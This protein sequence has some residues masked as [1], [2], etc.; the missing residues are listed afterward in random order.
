MNNREEQ[1]TNPS[2]F[3]YNLGLQ[4]SK[5][6]E[7]LSSEYILSKEG[8]TLKRDNETTTPQK[9]ANEIQH[10]L[11]NNGSL[12]L[13]DDHHNI[14]KILTNNDDQS[15]NDEEEEE[16]DFDNTLKYKKLQTLMFSNR[17][18]KFRKPAEE[19]KAAKKLD[20]FLT[21]WFIRYYKVRYLDLEEELKNCRNLE[22]IFEELNKL[23]Y[24]INYTSIR[25]KIMS[26]FEKR[27]LFQ[28]DENIKEPISIWSQNST[29]EILD[30]GKQLGFEKTES[31]LFIMNLYSLFHHFY[32]LLSTE[33]Y[34]MSDLKTILKNIF[35]SNFNKKDM[36][37]N[38]ALRKIILNNIDDADNFE[39]FKIVHVPTEN[40]N[41]FTLKCFYK[42]TN[43]FN[44]DYNNIWSESKGMEINEVEDNGDYSLLNEDEVENLQK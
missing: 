24:E 31:D 22:S 39:K 14:F 40:T 4:Y 38:K 34:S 28:D 10:F 20:E 29:D 19:L 15:D 23:D 17:S 1:N 3:G 2:R 6:I 12:T 21:G 8:D 27:F 43:K 9:W 36:L 35:N 25:G 32:R 44:Q 41:K 33:N 5:E 18:K 42:S 11:I 13:S 37:N 30:I 26:L 7:N 16:E